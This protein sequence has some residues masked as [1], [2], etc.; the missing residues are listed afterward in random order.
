MI[1]V[2]ELMRWLIEGVEV[3]VVLT[4]V[5]CKP[6]L[7]CARAS[8]HQGCCSLDVD[9]H[10]AYGVPTWQ[11]PVPLRGLGQRLEIVAVIGHVWEVSR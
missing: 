10:P 5:R 2:W 8:K 9:F 3:M 4:K 11:N 6:F 1:D 7:G